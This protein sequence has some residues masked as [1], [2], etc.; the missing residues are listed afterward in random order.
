MEDGNLRWFVLGL[1]GHSRELK[2]RDALRKSGQECFVPLRYEVKSVGGRQVRSWV[3]AVSGLLFVRGDAENVKNLVGDRRWG[4]YLRKSSFSN[5]KD[6]LVVSDRDMR[7]FIDFT[8]RAGERVKFFTP[9]EVVVRPGDIIRVS[10]TAYD[11]CEA[12]V[13]R[14]KGK[15]NKHLVV[16]VPGVICAAVELKPD[17]VTLVKPE[18]RSGNVEEDKKLLFRLAHRLLFEFTDRYQDNQEYY[19]AVS[20]LRRAHERL[21]SFKG[22]TPSQEGELALA[23]FLAAVKLDMNVEKMTER[24]KCAINRLQSTSLLRFRMQMY[25]AKLTND[26]QLTVEI[27]QSIDQWRTAAS[28]RQRVVLEEYEQLFSA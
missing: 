13:M 16:T 14:I 4:V 21:E 25:L 19:L 10:G 27:S 18:R 17:L 6:C 3:P 28:I 5:G 9:E 26:E 1:L 2:T 23:M 7:N 15:R 20:E 22:Y 11:G 12:V 8:E 24:L